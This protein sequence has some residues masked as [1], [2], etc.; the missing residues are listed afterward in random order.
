VQIDLDM[1]RKEKRRTDVVPGT[2]QLV[3]APAKDRLRFRLTNQLELSRSHRRSP[4][5]IAR[6]GAYV[7]VETE[8]SHFPMKS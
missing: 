6:L 3:E 5:R 4:S 2:D 7:L 8:P 1:R